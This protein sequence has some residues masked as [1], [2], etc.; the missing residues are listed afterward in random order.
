MIRDNLKL[1]LIGLILVSCESNTSMESINKIELPTVNREL[2]EDEIQIEAS[3]IA[4]GCACA[5]WMTRESQIEM[6][7]INE[8][9][10]AYDCQSLGTCFNIEKANKN[11]PYPDSLWDENG[12]IQFVRF[13]G[14]FYKEHQ[15]CPGHDDVVLHAKTFR[16]TSF[17]YVD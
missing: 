17:E 16:Y 12:K 14:R 4:W 3:Y 1:L 9:G 7:E 11:L 10:G 13:T 8:N 15:P 5:N 2:E 6:N